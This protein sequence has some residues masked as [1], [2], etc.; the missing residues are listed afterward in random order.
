M[1]VGDEFSVV[2]PVKDSIK[3]EWTKWQ[4]AILKKWARSGRMKARV[5]VVVARTDVSVAQIEHSC[6]FMQ[7]G[8]IVLPFTERPAPPL[9]TGDNFDRFAPRTAS[10][11]RW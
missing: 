1:K 10:R 3:I 4:D 6:D 7:R 2:R 11:W 8:D 5:K 9:K